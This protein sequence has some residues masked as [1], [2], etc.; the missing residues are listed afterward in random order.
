MSQGILYNFLLIKMAAT[1]MIN[2]YLASNPT[3]NLI[4]TDIMYADAWSCDNNGQYYL[5]LSVNW[6]SAAETVEAVYNESKNFI[7]LA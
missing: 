5:Q 6:T 4:E 3:D 1:K 2:E 7:T